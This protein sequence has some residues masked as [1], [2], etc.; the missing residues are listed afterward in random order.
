MFI[1]IHI[2][3]RRERGFPQA[4][5][6]KAYAT[7]DELIA[8]FDEDDV[9]AGVIMGGGGPECS[10]QPQSYEEVLSIRDD[11]PERFVPFLCF[12]P[13]M[14]TNSPEAPLDELVAFYKDKGCKGAGEIMANLPFT[15]PR[16]WNLFSAV[17]KNALPLTFHIATEIGG[18]YGLYDDPGLPG[19]EIS[20]IRFPDLVFLG[21]SQAFWSEI[22][23]L[24]SPGDRGGY[25]AGPIPKPGRVVELMRKHPNLHGDLSAGSGFNAVSRDEAFGIDFLNEFQDRL[26]YGS[27]ITHRDMPFKLRDWLI[28]M[29]DG[30]KITEKVFAKIA[31]KNAQKL[32][33]L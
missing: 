11:F 26:Y 15:D 4:W 21:H 9:D 33:G 32:L 23:E 7:P 14:L 17:Q 22:G 25:P 16:A 5:S 30:G 18:T 13:R 6:K 2:H 29:R 10:R 19:L 8:R 28:E 27:D 3:V 12:D 24:S 20:L 1:D 31:R